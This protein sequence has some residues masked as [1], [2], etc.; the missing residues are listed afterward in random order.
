[1]QNLCHPIKKYFGGWNLFWLEWNNVFR[2]LCSF[3]FPFDIKKNKNFL[4]QKHLYFFF[5]P[6]DQI[7]KI[8]CMSHIASCTIITI[9]PKF[10]YIKVMSICHIIDNY[11]PLHVTGIPWN[12]MLFSLGEIPNTFKPC[13]SCLKP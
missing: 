7:K 11:W 2:N 1:M 10:I 9:C 12:Q 4:L 8:Y 5:L 3:A 6:F 13:Q